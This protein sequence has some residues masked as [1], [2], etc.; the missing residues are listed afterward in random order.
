MKKETIVVQKLNQ[1]GAVIGTQL[2]DALANTRVSNDEK[3]KRLIS[4][5]CKIRTYNEM[6]NILKGGSV[7][8]LDMTP[9]SYY[10]K[11]MTVKDL[12]FLDAEKI[13]E[14]VSDYKSV[15][16]KGVK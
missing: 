5:Y 4:V 6:I 2:K 7:H 1:Y 13:M 3:E 10:F 14:Q 9:E 8:K 15:N 16:Y 12:Q 11:G